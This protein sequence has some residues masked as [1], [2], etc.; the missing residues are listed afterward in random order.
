MLL[1]SQFCD[2]RP[3]LF[4]HIPYNQILTVKLHFYKSIQYMYAFIYDMIETHKDD[5]NVRRAVCI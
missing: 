3:N 5:S 2:I 1:Q 4:D